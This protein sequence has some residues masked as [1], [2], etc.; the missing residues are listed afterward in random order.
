MIGKGRRGREGEQE[1]E[2]NGRI[3]ERDEKID[4]KGREGRG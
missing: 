3:E 4:G 2:E 1:R